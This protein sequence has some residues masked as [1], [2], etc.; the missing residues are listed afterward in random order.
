M[1]LFLSHMNI[2]SIDIYSSFY[3]IDILNHAYASYALYAVFC[4]I[5]RPLVP[6]KISNVKSIKEKMNE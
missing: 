1:S 6:N 2:I 5:L 3:F 4:G